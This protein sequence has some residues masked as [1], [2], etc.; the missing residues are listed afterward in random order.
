MTVSDKA[1]ARYEIP[2]ARS[3]DTGDYEC[4]VRADGKLGFS[5]S[6]YVW[7]AG[8]CSVRRGR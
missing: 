2:V 7:V 3:S 4:T 5:N 1:D 6:I 8:E